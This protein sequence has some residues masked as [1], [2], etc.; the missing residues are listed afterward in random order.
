MPTRD[1]GAAQFVD[2]PPDRGTAAESTIGILDTGVDLDHPVVKSTS[3]GERKIVD[4]VTYTDPAD[5]RRPD[6]ARLRPEADDVVGGKFDL[7]SAAQR[8]LHG[9]ARPTARTAS[10]ACGRTCSGQG[11]ST[12]SPAAPISTETA[13]AATSSPSLAGVGQQGLVDSD[14][15]LSFADESLDDRL[16]GQL[17]RRLLR[18]RQPGD[19]RR[20]SRCRS[21]SRPTRRT[22]SSTSASSPAR[23]ARTS[24]AS[25][26]ATACSAAR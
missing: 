11:A 24:R 25:P 18:A 22:R 14:N 15:D 13:L 4:W 19:A 5:R 10:H 1:T 20:A 7:V 23:T 6:L 26:P 21:S 12:A 2:A 9:R 17:R 16:Q 3:T 8:P